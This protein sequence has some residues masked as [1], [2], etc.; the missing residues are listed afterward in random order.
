MANNSSQYVLEVEDLSVEFHTPSG[1]VHAVSH[2]SFKLKEGETLGIV[3][4]SGSG[5]SVTA[6]SIMR[7]LP[8]TARVTGKILF[9][10]QDILKM[11][12]KDFNKIRGKE[13]SMIFQDPM[14]SLNP[15]Y[16]VGRQIDESISRIDEYRGILHIRRHLANTPIFKG[17]PNFRPTRIRLL[18]AETRAELLKIID[19]IEHILQN[20][21]TY[22][23]VLTTAGDAAGNADVPADG[24]CPEA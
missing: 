24:P 7:L 15:L 9:K 4:E 17:I 11:K 3:G 5:K 2:A 10:G 18:R 1:V 21:L 12:T 13:I 14:T 8:D 16:T 6:N 20:N 23:P 19:E 22:E